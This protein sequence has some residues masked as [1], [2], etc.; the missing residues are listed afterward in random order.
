MANKKTE[1]KSSKSYGFS[2]EQAITKSKNK[3]TKRN[4]PVRR[5]MV[6]KKKGC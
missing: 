1:S 5:T 6:A 3:K 2:P 4:V